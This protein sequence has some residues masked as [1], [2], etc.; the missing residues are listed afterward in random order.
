MTGKSTI[1]EAIN[2]VL[3]ETYHGKSIRNELTQYLF[4]KNIVEDCIRKVNEGAK[5][6]PTKIIIEAYF[7]G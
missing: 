1:L 2:L 4:N 3:T 7:D 6:E 5:V